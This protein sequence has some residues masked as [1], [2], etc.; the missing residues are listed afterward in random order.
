MSAALERVEPAV[1]LAR[2]QAEL[3]A[4]QAD[5][6]T[7][8][9]DDQVLDYGRQLERTRRL[10][11]SLD[12]RFIGELEGREL[13]AASCLRTVPFLR[14]LLRLD[15]REAS[16]RVSAAHAAGPRRALTG[17]PLPAVYP[18]VAAAQD[19]GEI[20]ERHGRIIVTT[21]EKLPDE[22]QAEYGE[23]IESELV[24]YAGRFDPYQLNR[25]ADRL[26]YC[27]DP[28][29]KHSDADY[30]EKTRGISVQHRP[31]GSCS[32]S[33]EGS[34]EFGEFLQLT[35]DAL[36]KPAPE[37]DGFKDPRSAAQRRHDAL[38]EA[39]K[40][41]VRAR[42]LLS[43][44]GVTATVIITMT[45]EEFESRKGLARTAHGALIPVPEAMRMTAGE[46]RL[47]NVVI[48][49]SQGIIAYSS[50]AR[51]FPEGARLAMVAHDGG[52]SFPNCNAPPGICEIDHI[53]DWAVGGPTRIDHGV[54][55]CRTHNVL[56][57]QQG[58][59]SARING[60]AAWIPPRWIDPAQRPRYNELHRTELPTP[61]DE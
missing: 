32:G 60:R 18:M 12:H 5:D 29:G 38:L 2:I 42:Q 7:A 44:A 6:L 43:V 59:R 47:M 1:R 36:G 19:A 50:T 31:D 8:L 40:L 33:F 11:P 13:P 23:Q 14:G 41:N 55:A 48:D 54:P 39:M 34:A 53:I 3:L 9:S 20:S 56:A 4:L 27:Y 35:F 16:A 37:A 57:K 61:D 22:V 46:Y 45:A 24:G 30:R 25:L 52:C 26:K 51:L 49:K 10:L 58:W 17:E 21:I 15:P 28:D